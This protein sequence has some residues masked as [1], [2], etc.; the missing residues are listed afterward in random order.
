[1]KNKLPII[2]IGIGV[3]CLTVWFFFVIPQLMNTPDFYEVSAQNVG[4]IQLADEVGSTLSDPVKMVFDW[5]GKIIKDNGNQIIIQTSYTYKDILTDEIFWEVIFDET[6]EKTTRQYIDKPGHFIFP[7]NLEQK[8]YQVYDVGGA[9]MNYNFVGV[10]EIDGLEVYEFVGSTTFDISE[11]YPDF[12]HQIFE[13][14][15]ATNLI[16]PKTGIDVSF[17]E[18]FTDYAIVDGQK[19][20]ILIAS[21]GPS[22]LSQKIL[23]QKVQSLKIL[24]E[25]YHEIMPVI[26]MIMTGVVTIMTLFQQKFKKAKKEFLE[27]EEKEKLKDEFVSMLNHEIRNPLTPIIAMCN[28]LLVE[29]DGNLNEKQRERLEL[30][31]KNGHILKELLSDFADVKKFDLEQ[32]QLSKTEVDLKEYLE[33]VLENVMSF[34]GKKDIQL[35][36]NLDKS[37]KISC[38]QTRI[39]QV[40]SNLVKNAIDFVPKD[41]GKIMI[42]A[43]LTKEGTIISVADN[44]IGIPS[45]DAEIIFEKFKQLDSPAD[46]QHEGSGLGLSIC[47]VIVEAHGG[48]IW[49]DTSYDAGSKF[50]FLIP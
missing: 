19:I 27:L 2:T 14:Y 20:P 40:I 13:D 35:S 11:I 37:W 12:D 15:S 4:T 1:M 29:K 50:Q 24:H 42:S 30:I 26:I 34:T 46:I 9:V 16:E 33:N 36:L 3:L 41:N 5:D 47:K 43:E 31:L 21:D 23:I 7:Y 6:V 32:G 10:T 48:R 38:D 44:G 22:E 8:D 17:T 28:L 18:E 39:S 25:I 45:N 49:L